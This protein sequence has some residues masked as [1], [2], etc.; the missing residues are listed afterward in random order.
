MTRAR[1]RNTLRP[2]Q[3][4][5]PSEAMSVLL[6]TVRQATCVRLRAHFLKSIQC[7][8]RKLLMTHVG[9]RELPHFRTRNSS[10]LRQLDKTT[11]KKLIRFPLSPMHSPAF[12]AQNSTQKF[13]RFSSWHIISHLPVLSRFSEETASQINISA[14]DGAGQHRRANL[15]SD[16]FSIQILSRH[17]G[18]VFDDSFRALSGTTY[19]DVRP[20]SARS[21]TTFIRSKSDTR[22][23]IRCKSCGFQ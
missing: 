5:S 11:T 6:Q 15:E 17:C 4:P 2:G 1:T 20:F 18:N 12:G 23:R 22:H 16:C 14:S 21:H 7:R 13:D 3:V 10:A 9:L 19:F 8:T